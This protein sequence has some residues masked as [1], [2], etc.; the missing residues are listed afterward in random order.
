MLFRSSA[1][2]LLM[3]EQLYW[4]YALIQQQAVLKVSRIRSAR[5]WA[6]S[7]LSGAVDFLV[8]GCR[9][10]GRAKLGGFDWV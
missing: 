5:D 6:T 9:M 8:L 3:I 2:G 10:R 7:L 4:G 1:T